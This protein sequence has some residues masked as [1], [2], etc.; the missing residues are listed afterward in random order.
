MKVLLTGG[1]GYIGS[2]TAVTLM[3]NGH[4][5][6]LVDNLANS[7][8]NVLERINRTT[9]NQPEF[10]EGDLAD[11]AFINHVLAV[12]RP[13]AVMH[14]AGLKAVAES[15]LQPL[16]YY[17]TNLITSLNLCQAMLDAGVHQLVFSS[18]ATVYGKPKQLPIYEDDQTEP[19]SPYGRTKLCIE[20]MLKDIA[21]AKPDMRIAM[22]R[23]FNPA[24]AH[25]SGELGED[26]NGQSSNLV[27]AILGVLA[28]KQQRLT[29][30]GNDYNTPDG[31]CIRDY[32]HVMDL[33]QGH[34]AALEHLQNHQ[35]VHVYNLG[36]G[37][38]HSVLEVIQSFEQAGSGKMSW[39]YGLRRPGDIAAIYADTSKARDELG[40]KAARGLDDICLDALR[41]QLEHHDS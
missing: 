39:E 32:I 20:Q 23:Y 40:W 37:K 17:R 26:L 4:D 6:V 13:D 10:H 18:S 29:V 34:L 3:V 12:V 25:E 21:S 22:L 28:G 14:F 30:F 36:T 38:G 33:A 11:L 24:G 19:V 2:H 8:R 5:V 35:G 16:R 31:T 41:W 7:N 27:P 9:G 15:V 1:T